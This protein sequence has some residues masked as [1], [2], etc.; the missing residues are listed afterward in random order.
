[1]RTFLHNSFSSKHTC[2][3][4]VFSLK[5]IEG[6]AD[7]LKELLETNTL[8]SQKV[9]PQGSRGLF[10]LKTDLSRAELKEKLPHR[11]VHMFYEFKS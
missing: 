7:P 11:V 5:A 3:V 1:M 2:V 4:W 6:N 9:V 10:V 8:L